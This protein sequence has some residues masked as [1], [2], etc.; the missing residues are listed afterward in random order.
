ME[1][2][3]QAAAMTE[4]RR[5]AGPFLG[6]CRQGTP[7]Q[8]LLQRLAAQS[9]SPWVSELA[10]A[11]EGKRD[12]IRLFEASIALRHEPR[13][14]VGLLVPPALS[15]REREVLSELARGATYADIGSA[16]FVSENTVKTHV[17]SLYNKLGAGRRSEALST[18]R[19][20]R[21]I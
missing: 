2:L 16:L 13:E 7:I 12:I 15:P 1:L 19:R 14:P 5:N 6:W 4:V 3:A 21:L 11:G 17:S 9:S 10:R 20:L 8:T 18:A